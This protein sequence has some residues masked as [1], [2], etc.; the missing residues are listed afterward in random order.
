M[1]V[2]KHRL[3]LT[4]RFFS[5]HAKQR[6]FLATDFLMSLYV[7]LSAIVEI[8]VVFLSILL[9]GLTLLM[10]ADLFKSSSFE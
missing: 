10:I 3:S 2:V 8:L 9:L 1:N 7:M 4:R 6:F 5:L